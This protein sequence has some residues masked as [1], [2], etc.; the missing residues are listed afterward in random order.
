MPRL[1]FVVGWQAY[2]TQELGV[3]GVEMVWVTLSSA[4]ILGIM[5]SVLNAG[6]IYNTR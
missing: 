1:V 5:T 2:L 6:T 4:G 3:N